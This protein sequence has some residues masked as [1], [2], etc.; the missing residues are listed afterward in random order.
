MSGTLSDSSTN[1]PIPTK[2]KKG[3]DVQ[4]AFRARKAA[5]LADLETKTAIYELDNAR[6]KR[7]N[8]A[9]KLQNEELKR[10]LEIAMSRDRHGHG[11]DMLPIISTAVHH[12]TS[13]TSDARLPYENRRLNT[14][15]IPGVS[16][17]QRDRQ[18][19]L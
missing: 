10:A 15:M 13:S 4:R 2:N 12:G 5:H 8:T 18:C 7:E 17:S 3:L 6:L 11:G 14:N 19:L 9:L 1:A 16:R